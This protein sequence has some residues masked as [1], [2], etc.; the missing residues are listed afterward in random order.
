MGKSIKLKDNTYWDSKGITHNN[1]LLSDILYPIGSVYMSVNSTS[2]ATLFGGTWTQISGRFLYC[3][4]T[5]K[6]TGGSSTINLSH[7]HTVNSHTHT[8]ASH[9]HGT[10]SMSACIGSPSGNAS[11]LGFAACNAAGPNS[12]YSVGGNTHQASGHPGRSHNTLITGTTDNTTPGNTGASSPSTNAQLSS[13]QS[14]LP[15][16]F[17]VYCW[18]RTA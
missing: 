10:G 1:K 14:I 6:T 5:S 8:S 12:T 11:A 17:T 16:Y 13:S 7:S 4:T 18:Y 3:T 9:N 2:P 15:P